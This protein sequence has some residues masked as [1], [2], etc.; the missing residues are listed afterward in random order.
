MQPAMNNDA[1]RSRQMGELNVSCILQ[2]GV[3]GDLSQSL[4]RVMGISQ[5]G[6]KLEAEEER[7]VRDITLHEHWLERKQEL[8]LEGKDFF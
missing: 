7:A 3:I 4:Y 6:R 1:K 5:M 8:N 2:C